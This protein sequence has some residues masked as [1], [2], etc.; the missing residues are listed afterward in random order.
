MNQQEVIEQHVSPVMDDDSEMNPEKSTFSESNQV[1]SFP[2]HHHDEM[3]NHDCEESS[4]SELTHQVE[5]AASSSVVVPH[6]SS[7]TPSQTLEEEAT[8]AL[9]DNHDDT[10][11]Q[12]HE[13][14]TTTP[15]IMIDDSTQ[16]DTT[17]PPTSTQQLHLSSS[18]YPFVEL[19][20]F[21]T[22]SVEVIYD[23]L[24]I[25]S[26]P[27][28]TIITSVNV[29]EEQS[30]ITEMI[31]NHEKTLY[32]DHP[33]FQKTGLTVSRK[34]KDFEWL[35]DHLKMDCVGCLIPPKE[36]LTTNIDK[37]Y[38]HHNSSTNTSSDNTTNHDTNGD[39]KSLKG[40]YLSIFLSLCAR[41]PVLCKSHLFWDFI[42]A[43]E[44]E[45]NNTMKQSDPTSQNHTLQT[46]TSSNTSGNTS[47]SNSGSGNTTSNSGGGG[48]L[49]SLKKMKVKYN[50]HDKE[51]E[52][53]NQLSKQLKSL[54]NASLSLKKY[55]ETF[56]SEFDSIGRAFKVYGNFEANNNFN[57][58]MNHSSTSS[59]SSTVPNNPNDSSSTTN[60]SLNNTGGTLHNIFHSIGDVTMKLASINTHQ[61]STT[62]FD[63]NLLLYT[64]YLLPNLLKFLDLSKEYHTTLSVYENDLNKATT[65]ANNNSNNPKY[66]E[67][68][69]KLTTIYNDMKRTVDLIDQ[70]FPLEW[71]RFRYEMKIDLQFSM[72]GSLVKRAHDNVECVK[73]LKESIENSHVDQGNTAFDEN[74][75]TS[76]NILR[77]KSVLQETYDHILHQHKKL[78]LPSGSTNRRKD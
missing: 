10:M 9:N 12:S 52:Y 59:S 64:K 48:L 63:Q 47:G 71:E 60:P 45:F 43:S 49:F 44:D 4:K 76:T 26:T 57:E 67:Q 54:L 29:Q 23:Q 13:N 53:V 17:P 6:S 78:I 68:V 14:T 31:Q 42:S 70:R 15:S 73:V 19:S 41:H 36:L 21:T 11:I 55:Q 22:T 25:Y 5:S 72:L 27:L 33:L 51:R 77:R 38:S 56:L 34:M 75:N 2:H 61:E 66:Q 18:K 3:N 20:S 58:M 24:N 37:L 8:Q 30:H 39:N 32:K 50:T 46:T 69:Q 7:A 40:K 62:Q 35:Y 28:F 65:Q 16:I 74:S 1:E